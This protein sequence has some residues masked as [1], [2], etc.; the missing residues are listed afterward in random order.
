MAASVDSIVISALDGTCVSIVAV[1]VA[2]PLDAERF[3]R[4][5]L[6]LSQTQTCVS[7]ASP[8]LRT[9]ANNSGD[10]LEKPADAT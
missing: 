1:D 10:A 6:F 9:A 8:A 7:V 2:C 3:V 4:A 5:S